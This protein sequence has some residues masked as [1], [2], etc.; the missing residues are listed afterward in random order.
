MSNGK[1]QKSMIYSRF[2]IFCYHCS[3]FSSFSFGFKLLFRI[4]KIF[5]YFF[6]LFVYFFILFVNF[7]ILFDYFLFYLFIYNFICLIF[8]LFMI[9]CLLSC[10]FPLNK[11]FKYTLKGMIEKLRNKM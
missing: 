4:R 8:I 10:V 2:K 5:F 1:L 6:T 3:M 9:Y 11:T 7:F